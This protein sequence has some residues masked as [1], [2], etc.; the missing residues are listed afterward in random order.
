MDTDSQVEPAAAAPPTT[1][2][3]PPQARCFGTG[4]PLYERYHDEEW[5]LRPEPTPDERELLERLVLEA[6]QSGLSWL[7]VLRKREALRRAFSGFDPVIV[8]SYTQEDVARLMQDSA[9]VRNRAKIEA[10]VSDAR[11]LLAMHERGERLWDLL[12]AYAPPPLP[13][14]AERIEQVPSRSPESAALAR[15]LKRRGFAFVGP[16]TAHATLQAVGLAD[17]HLASCRRPRGETRVI[18]TLEP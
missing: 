1:P 16:T 3:P 14:P 4:D 18:D 11:A 15:E 17:G 10:A 2:E 6:F 5:G 8:A 7:T 12:A 13:T 9:I